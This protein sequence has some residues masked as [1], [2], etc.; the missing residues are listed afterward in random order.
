MAAAAAN[1]AAAAQGEAK[2]LQQQLQPTLYLSHGSPT[3]VLQERSPAHQFLHRL[4]HRLLQG[5][6]AAA[7]EAKDAAGDAEAAAADQKKQAP[8]GL[9][10]PSGIV[11]ISAH[12]ETHNAGPTV[13]GVA[14]PQI[15]YDFGGGFPRQLFEFQYD[16]G[17]LLAGS[18]KLASHVHNLLN[19]ESPA[20]AAKILAALRK[21]GFSGHAAAADSQPEVQAE[22]V[23]GWKSL[24]SKLDPRRGWDHGTWTVLSLMFPS[25][26]PPHDRNPACCEKLVAELRKPAT[27]IPVV[28]ISLPRNHGPGWL[29]QQMGER[30][31]WL[32]RENILVMGSG[33]AV[34]NLGEIDFDVG[35]DPDSLRFLGKDDRWQAMFAQLKASNRAE[36]RWANDFADWIRQK[37]E[38][39][40]SAAALD[41]ATQAPRFSGKR[42]HPTDEHFTPL[43]VTMGAGSAPWERPAGVAAAPEQVAGV[44]IHEGFEFGNL[45]MHSFAWP[46]AE[47]PDRKAFA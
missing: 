6:D 5:D 29:M 25:R 16:Y 24:H 17:H 15:I 1:N 7:D 32:R 28:Q 47:F 42:S 40:D 19:S 41:F 45:G 33:A 14:K 21:D 44:T 39:G 11:I 8:P 10:T 46:R 23:G 38:A 12:W 37:V 26:T 18:P 36:A 4:G 30:L 35:V 3:I 2:Q 27:L 9:R 20:E 13:T 43:F 34:H 31:A 22:P